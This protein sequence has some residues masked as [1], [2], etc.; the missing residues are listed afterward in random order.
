MIYI[1]YIPRL[2]IMFLPSP[3]PL[4]SLVSTLGV[5]AGP[6]PS[7]GLHTGACSVASTTSSTGL[8][9]DESEFSLVS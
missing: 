5:C 4:G 8:L 2:V 7:L 1:R 3:L 6:L 9:E